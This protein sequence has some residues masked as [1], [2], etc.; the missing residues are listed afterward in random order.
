MLEKTCQKT[1][2]IEE[3]TAESL[4]EEMYFV[5]SGATQR[6]TDL[7]PKVTDTF[8]FEKIISAL[9]LV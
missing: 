8:Q 5:K 4:G 9:L 1:Q 3:K 7:I 6:S 2:D